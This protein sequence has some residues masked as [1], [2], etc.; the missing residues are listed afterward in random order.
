MMWVAEM[1]PAVT[2]TQPTVSSVVT[3]RTD[4][5]ACSGSTCTESAAATTTVTCANA[6]DAQYTIKLYE[7]G[8]QVT[9]GSTAGFTY[10]KT[11]YNYTTS[12]GYPFNNP[13]LTY[14]ADVVVLADSSVV[15]SKTGNR[16]TDT[17]GTCGGL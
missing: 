9:T 5:G 10:V 15:Q 4:D 14:R 17:L 16:Y 6:N 13:D 7:N 11:F 1:G 8:V 3:A 2:G 12:G